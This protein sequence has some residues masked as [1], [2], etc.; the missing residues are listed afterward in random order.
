[1]LSPS[2]GAIASDKICRQ[3]GGEFLPIVFCTI[4][5][6]SDYKF[7]PGI[8]AAVPDDTVGNIFRRLRVVLVGRG[9]AASLSFS[10]SIQ[11]GFI[12]FVM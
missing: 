10:S 11:V 12:C 2:G 7:C 6:S 9:V 3:L 5:V 1:M 8:R 4:P